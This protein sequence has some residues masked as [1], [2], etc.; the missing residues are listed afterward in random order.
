MT[1]YLLDVNLLLALADP[2]HLHHDAAHQWFKTVGR[3][4]WA[5]CPTTENGFLRIASNPK[6]PNRPGDVATVLAILRQFCALDGHTFWGDSPSIR[7]ILQVEAVLTH[8]HV[9]DIY[10]LG[11]AVH[12]NGKLATLD[13]RISTSAVKDGDVALETIDVNN[14]AQG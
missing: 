7:D 8:N 12:N 9:T 14:L 6:Y 4:S 11:L 1:T 5:T 3:Q 13:Q 2:M 10:L